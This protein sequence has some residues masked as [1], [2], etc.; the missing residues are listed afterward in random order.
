LQSPVGPGLWIFCVYLLGK[1]FAVSLIPH[2]TCVVA[3]C[4]KRRPGVTVDTVNN[5]PEKPL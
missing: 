4:A 3:S 5:S 2:K 1:V